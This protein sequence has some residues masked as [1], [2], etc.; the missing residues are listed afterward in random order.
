M[1]KANSFKRLGYKSWEQLVLEEHES[2]TP[3]ALATFVLREVHWDA[4]RASQHVLNEAA[5]KDDFFPGQ[6]DSFVQARA[7]KH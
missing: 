4:I 3:N 6:L 2:L 1:R 5:T 7:R